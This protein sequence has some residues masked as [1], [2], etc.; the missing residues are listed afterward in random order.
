[1]LCGTGGTCLLP[2]ADRVVLGP[3]CADLVNVSFVKDPALFGTHTMQTR[4]DVQK[5]AALFNAS[6]G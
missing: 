2:R 6:H 5:A 1:M 4:D 3:G